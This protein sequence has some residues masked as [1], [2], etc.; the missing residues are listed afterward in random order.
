M[1]K[2][3]TISKKVKA[4]TATVVCLLLNS[5][6]SSAQVG[7]NSEINSKLGEVI[8]N[9]K[10]PLDLVVGGLG[11][12]GG[13]LIFFQYKSGKPEAKDNL[14]KLVIGLAVWFL[15]VPILKVFGLASGIN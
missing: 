10:G 8:N 3:K 14:I 2:V 5:T 6:P 15:I 11:L 1:K 12:V 7:N 4:A 13:F 9:I